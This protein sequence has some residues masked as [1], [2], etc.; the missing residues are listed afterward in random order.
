MTILIPAFPS[1][2][3]DGA[4]RTVVATIGIDGRPY[5]RRQE[6]ASPI[7][8]FGPWTPATPSACGNVYY[9]RGDCNGDGEVVGTVTDAVFLLG[10]N[11]LGRTSPP[12]LA[13]C[14]ANGDGAV[15]GDVADAIYLLRHNF[16]G[17]P[18][19]PG[20][21]PGCGLATPEDTALRCD[22]PPTAC[23]GGDG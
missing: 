15:I 18:P 10:F 11:F 21:Y 6:S 13:A 23:P 22:E 8:E 2:A 7:A 4:G 5:L 17:G 16:L 9:L 1:A 14:D 20:P 3:V 12:C 19:P